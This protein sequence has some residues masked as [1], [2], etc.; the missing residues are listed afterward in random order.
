MSDNIP[1]DGVTDEQLLS[2][3]ADG[4]LSGFTTALANHGAP[5]A[6]SHLEGHAVASAMLHDPASR[7]EIV[8]RARAAAAGQPYETSS[9]SLRV[10]HG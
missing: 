4:F 7:H 3:F 10:E 9:L 5:A 2:L 1:L 8:T 6:E